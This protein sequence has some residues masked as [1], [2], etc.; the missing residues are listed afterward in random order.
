M[1]LSSETAGEEVYI[2]RKEWQASLYLQLRRHIFRVESKV[3]TLDWQ[4]QI[5]LRIRING[6]GLG[7]GIRA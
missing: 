1:L 5:A 3:A 2:L 6:F 4:P 7:G